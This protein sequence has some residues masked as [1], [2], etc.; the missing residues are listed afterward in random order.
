MR[1][2]LIEIICFLLG[3]YI[4]IIIHIIIIIKEY[5]DRGVLSSHRKYSQKIKKNID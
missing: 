1:G 5:S 3:V 2:C 4:I